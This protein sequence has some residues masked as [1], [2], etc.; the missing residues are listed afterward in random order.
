M[1]SAR[2]RSCID[3]D[4]GERLADLADKQG[5]L[6]AVN[7]NAALGS[8][9]SVTCAEAVEADLIGQVASVHCGVHWDHSWVR[10]T[11]FEKVY[12]LH[13]V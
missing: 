13:P 7:Q 5:L 10:G 9:I 6:L 3:L 11:I 8:L 12:H 2:S 1:C 4:E